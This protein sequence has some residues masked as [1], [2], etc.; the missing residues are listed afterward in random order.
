MYKTVVIVSHSWMIADRSFGKSYRR[1][2]FIKFNT[3]CYV[4]MSVYSERYNG[5]SFEKKIKGH[6]RHIKLRI[7]LL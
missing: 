1:F 5:V 4:V 7:Y 3:S 6:F 2:H